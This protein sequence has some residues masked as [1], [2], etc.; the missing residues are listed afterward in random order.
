MFFCILYEGSS[1]SA[2]RLSEIWHL[3]L[4]FRRYYLLRTNRTQQIY[5]SLKKYVTHENMRESVTFWIG[6]APFKYILIGWPVL[7]FS[8]ISA[9]AT[10]GLP[11]LSLTHSLTQVFFR[12]WWTISQKNKKSIAT[13]I[14]TIVSHFMRGL[15]EHK[16]AGKHCNIIKFVCLL[17]ENTRN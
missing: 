1:C 13:F 5:W 7:T 6:Q 2:L 17:G 15:A 11:C 12:S 4:A 16:K 3:H 14:I 8:E 9:S 10:I